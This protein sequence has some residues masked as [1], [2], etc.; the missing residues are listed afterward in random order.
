MSQ[1]AH[2]RYWRIE[3]SQDCDEDEACLTAERWRYSLAS[4]N[5]GCVRLEGGTYVSHRLVTSPDY[6]KYTLYTVFLL[7]KT[8][9]ACTSTLLRNYIVCVLTNSNLRSK[10]VMRQEMRSKWSVVEGLNGGEQHYTHLRDAYIYD[11]I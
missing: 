6:G 8:N 9:C 2:F 1:S 10:Q 5:G 11:R 3:V 4:L 7:V